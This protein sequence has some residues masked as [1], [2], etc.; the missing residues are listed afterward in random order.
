MRI[1]LKIKDDS[2]L[3]VFIQRRMSTT[4]LEQSTVAR[5]ILH[6]AMVADVP[7]PTPAPPA[8]PAP[9]EN[10]EPDDDAV[11]AGLLGDM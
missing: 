3:G 10:D 1:V 9:V 2:P 6:E 5:L 4:G 11:L 8:P 7:V